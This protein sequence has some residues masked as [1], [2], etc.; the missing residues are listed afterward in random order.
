LPLFA[1]N[2]PGV[3]RALAAREEAFVRFETAC[4]R[5]LAQLEQRAR[6]AQ[7]ARTQHERLV[8]EVAPVAQRT[9]ELARRAI[10]A[11][12]GSAL[13]LLEA[14][15]AQQQVALDV[16][17]AEIG[18]R[19]AWSALERAVGRPLAPLCPQDVTELPTTQIPA[20]LAPVAGGSR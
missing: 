4:S 10:A 1:R 5:A 20:Q 19:A 11:G 3:A 6:A 12:T 15:R 8:R 16:L 14:E 9:A 2:Q 18:W 7:F 17:D 13:R